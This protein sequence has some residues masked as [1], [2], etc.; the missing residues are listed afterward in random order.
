MKNTAEKTMFQEEL[1]QIASRLKSE[2][3]ALLKLVRELNN[4]SLIQ[5]EIRENQKS[6]T[7][8]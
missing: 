1:K 5:S 2:N 8:K 4:S 3:K 6:K 7:I